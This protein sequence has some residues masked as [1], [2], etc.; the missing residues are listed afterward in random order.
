MVPREAEK[1]CGFPHL[2]G[3]YRYITVRETTRQN[4]PHPGVSHSLPPGRLLSTGH[5]FNTI[6]AGAAALKRFSDFIA[7]C[8][9]QDDR[10]ITDVVATYRLQSDTEFSFRQLKEPDAVLFSPLPHWTEHNIRVRAFS[11]VP[12]LQIAHLM[13][14]QGRPPQNASRRS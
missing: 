2:W 6:R 5:A 1:H 8:A 11:Y 7:D 12:A 3:T 9:P 10:S 4:A 13:R 14:R